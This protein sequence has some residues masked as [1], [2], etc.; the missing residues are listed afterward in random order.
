MCYVSEEV[1]WLPV[2]KHGLGVSENCL[3]S[4]S[5]WKMERCIDLFYRVLVAVV[6]GECCCEDD[7]VVCF[8]G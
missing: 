6:A 1:T 3:D 8:V 7:S 2:C 4:F 5:S